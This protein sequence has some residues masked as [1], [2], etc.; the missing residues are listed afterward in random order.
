CPVTG[1]ESPRYPARLFSWI[2]PPSRCLRTTF[3]TWTGPGD[4]RAPIAGLA[5]RGGPVR[6]VPAVECMGRRSELPPVRPALLY[7]S[8]SG[9][10]PALAGQACGRGRA[11]GMAQV[12][13]LKF[14]LLMIPTCSQTRLRFEASDLRPEESTTNIAWFKARAGSI[15]EHV[16]QP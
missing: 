3:A 11:L 14:G 10:I 6:G 9:L 7:E 1:R 16:D 4:R 12:E 15:L 5:V 2:R 13:G 8:I